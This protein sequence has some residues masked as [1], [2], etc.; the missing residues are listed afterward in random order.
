MNNDTQRSDVRTDAQAIE[1][2][3]S[4]TRLNRLWYDRNEAT[5]AE[6]DRLNSEYRAESAFF[7][8]L[9]HTAPDPLEITIMEVLRCPVCKRDTRTLYPDGSLPDACGECLEP[10]PDTI[11]D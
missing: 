6:F 11:G 4:I 10:W 8:S 9:M 2:E 1:T 7:Q 5:G 3:K